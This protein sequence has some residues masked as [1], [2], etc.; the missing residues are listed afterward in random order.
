MSRCFGQE[1][2]TFNWTPESRDAD[3]IRFPHAHT[4]PAITAGQTVLRP[5]DLHRAHILTGVI[6]LPTVIRLA[7]AEFSVS[8][9]TTIG[10]HLLMR[11]KRPSPPNRMVDVMT[12][13]P[14]RTLGI[15]L[16]SQPRQT[17]ACLIAWGAHGAVVERIEAGLDDAALEALVARADLTGIDAPFGW[18]TPFVQWLV[19]SHSGGGASDQGAA[20]AWDAGHVRRLRFRA[21]DHVVRERLGRWPLSVATDLIS[22]VAMRCTGLLQQLGVRDKLGGDSVVEVYPALALALWGIPAAGYKGSGKDEIRARVLHDG[23]LVRCPWLAMTDTQ[24][25]Q[26]IR[27]D[28]MLDALLA[29][30]VA[31]CFAVGAVEPIDARHREAAQR[32]G[33][34]VIPARDALGRLSSAKERTVPDLGGRKGGTCALSV[35][36]QAT[37]HQP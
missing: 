12:N 37:S 5:G 36:P 9:F 17:A 29:S 11:L 16:A 26:C 8:R 4:G 7:I 27:S 1:M 25:A 14:M 10:R 24:T 33:W 34:I 31:R 6:S 18:P 19:Q 32:E 21:T 13:Q 3:A 2:L 35:W 28:H 15:D 20:P 23:L 30:L 22:I